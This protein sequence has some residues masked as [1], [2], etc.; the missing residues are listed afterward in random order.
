MTQKE[1]ILADN[2]KALQEV[3]ALLSERMDKLTKQIASLLDLFERAAVKFNKDSANPVMA[4]EDTD[5]LNKLD[6]LLEENKTIAKAL[7]LLEQR[8]RN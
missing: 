8:V 7:S 5:L 3:L 2:F 4:K 1:E 6:R